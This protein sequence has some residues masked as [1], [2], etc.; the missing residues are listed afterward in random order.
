MKKNKI[1]II[2]SLL[3]SCSLLAQQEG[4]SDYFAQIFITQKY[5]TE[6]RIPPPVLSDEAT[7]PGYPSRLWRM[8]ISGE[9]HYKCIVDKQGKILKY[10]II[11]CTHTEFGEAFARA[12]KT[13]VFKRIDN[14]FYREKGNPEK[15]AVMDNEDKIYPLSVKGVIKFYIR[16]ED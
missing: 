2:M 1:I 14:S 8:G 6:L 10:E 13:W 11:K 4:Y 7:L 3:L 12:V 5:E 16:E 15:K 9:I